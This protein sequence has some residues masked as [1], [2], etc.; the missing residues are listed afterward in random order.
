MI[1]EHIFHSWRSIKVPM[2]HYQ[3]KHQLM[4]DTEAMVLCQDFGQLKCKN[5]L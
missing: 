2:G 5:Y 1:L 3:R 4:Q